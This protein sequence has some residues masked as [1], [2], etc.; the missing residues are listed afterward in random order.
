MNADERDDA[1]QDDRVLDASALNALLERCSGWTHGPLQAVRVRRFGQDRGYAGRVVHVAGTTSAGR[2]ASCVV[3]L[4]THDAVR[5]TLALHA[6]AGVALGDATAR[7]FG[8]V[9]AWRGDEGA[10]VFEDLTALAPGDVLAGCTPAQACDVL[11]VLARLHAATWDVDAHEALPEWDPRPLDAAIWRERLAL[12]AE[13][14]PALLS[15][16]LVARLIDLPERFA[17]SVDAARHG[18]RCVIHADVHLDNVLL[19]DEDSVVLLDWDGA[20]FGPP[21]VDVMRA[22]LEC[23]GP[24]SG[25]TWPRCLAAYLLELRTR[26]IADVGARDVLGDGTPVLVPMLQGVIG[27]VGRPGEHPA[28]PRM[29]VLLADIVLKVTRLLGSDDE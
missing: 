5:R 15:A 3:K 29:E 21:A 26:G 13:R 25:R 11:R 4:A 27:A 14:H 20:R 16:P 23:A 22:L 9:V 12:A 17:A 8:G 28:G 7:C 1:T 18:P 6:L 10:L 19:R 2:A 24:P